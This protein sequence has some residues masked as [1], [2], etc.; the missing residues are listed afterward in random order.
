MRLLLKNLTLGTEHEIQARIKSDGTPSEWSPKF[1]FTTVTDQ[2]TPKTPTGI[3][4]VSESDSYVA[5]WTTV[6][7]NVD[8]SP[9]AILR[10]AMELRSGGVVKAFPVPGGEDA[11]QEHGW[12]YAQIKQL[13]GSNTSSVEFRIRAVNLSKLKSE[14]SSW[15]TATTLAPNPPTNAVVGQ[16]QPIS[17]TWR[18]TG[19][20]L[21]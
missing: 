13:F 16:H 15:H 12:T 19:Y 3:T 2:V 17:P 10:Y 11:T 14:W 9:A 7:E 6:T 5:R 1:K 21:D 4:F 8:G 18:G 20:M